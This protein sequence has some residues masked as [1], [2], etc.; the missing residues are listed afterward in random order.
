MVKRFLF[1]ALLLI[2]CAVS[3]SAYSFMADGIAYNLNSDGTTVT[4]YFYSYGATSS[5]ELV[6]PESITFGG[7]TYTITAIAESA[8]ANNSGLT[9]VTI[10]NSVT[11]IGNYA[12]RNCTGL[13]SVTIGNS[14]TSI[15]NYAFYDCS[16]LTSIDIPDS[17][18]EIGSD[19]FSGTVWNNNQPDGLVYAGLVAYSYK[20]VMPAGI[21]IV[22]KEG[23]KSISPGC[24]S[25]C[26][27]LTSVNIPNSVTTIGNSAFY[28]CRDL[29]SVTIGNSVTKI[30]YS[31]FYDC[32]GIERINSY[33]DP[34]KV[35]LGSEVFNGVPKGGTLHVLPQYLEAYKAADQW[36]EFTNIKGDLTE[37]G[38]DSIIGVIKGD[39]N[40]DASVDGNDVSILLEMVLGGK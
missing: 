10:P 15:G 40:G 1:A 16:G 24:F 8:F 26:S 36:S 20:G 13:T 27:S 14:V 29:T 35:T 34:A 37:G 11:S 5:G 31:A 38:N 19:A 21:S 17:V 2:M 9:S 39:L 12:F 18:T 25:G 28:G 4:L 22:L 33:L 32:I 30:D 3:A 7:D 23:T 6:I